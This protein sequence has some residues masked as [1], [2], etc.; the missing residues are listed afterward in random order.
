MF[1]VEPE[2]AP[3]KNISGFLLVQEAGILVILLK[4]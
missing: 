2:M 1:G 4:G 3:Q